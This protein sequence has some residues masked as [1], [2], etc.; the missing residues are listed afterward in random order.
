ML[1]LIDGDIPV[2]S[3]SKIAEDEPLENCLHSIK[4]FIQNIIDTVGADE[5][6]IYLSGE[7]NFRK[8]VYPQYK[9]NRTEPK[10]KHFKDAREYLIKYWDAVVLDGWEAD[11]SLGMR[12]NK[13]SNPAEADTI[14]A[15]IDKDMMMVPGLHYTWEIRRK[16]E[17]V[18][19]KK[20]VWIDEITGWRNFCMQCLTGDSTDNIPG[21]KKT[22][23]VKDLE[24]NILVPGVIASAKKK[25][26]ITK[27]KTKR[28]MWNWVNHL[29]KGHEEEL[30]VIAQLLWILR[31]EGKTYRDYL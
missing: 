30:H 27:C 23:E 2:H 26:I 14:I 24:G 21:L 7:D 12:Q 1:V 16:G 8:T 5:Y 17:V 11:D 6:I 3:I 28:G 20:S 31:D 13:T 10:P 18:R 22:T 15:S 25:S 4:L 9:A 29:Y 19:K